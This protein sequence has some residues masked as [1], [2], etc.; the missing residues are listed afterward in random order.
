M[1]SPALG[2]PSAAA[3]FGWQSLIITTLIQVLVSGGALTPPVF[4]PEA[5]HDLGLPAA[6]IGFYTSLVYLGATLA[7]P[8]S[9]DL[10]GRHGPLR[11]SQICLLL[12]GIG[13]L[14]LTLTPFWPWLAVGSALLIGF[15]YGP[16]TPASSHILART[17]PAHR[18]GLVFSLKQ[19]GVPLGGM[20][21]GFAVPPL[22]YLWGWQ[23]A[24]AV[25][26]GVAIILA[27]AVQPARVTLDCQDGGGAARTG[28]WWR[29]IIGPV[30]LVW[31]HRRLRL[32]ACAS[33][34]FT[35]MQLSLGTFWVSYL[36]HDLSLTLLQAGVILAASQGG[37]VLGRILWGLMADRY[38]GARSM[39]LLLAVLMSACAL[40]PLALSPEWSLTALAL[41]SAGFGATA[42][43][44]NGVFLAEV[45]HMAPLGRTGEATGGVLFYTYAGVVFGPSLFG[46]LI[47][48]LGG[49]AQT[50]CVFSAL[51]FI[52]GLLIMVSGSLSEDKNAS[53]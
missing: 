11:T 36:V 10:I 13:L 4:A 43:G 51:T 39:L 33:F 37:G 25:V 49:Y 21:A 48:P 31:R 23:G 15:G 27:V 14:C 32:F 50:F 34:T 45:A 20:V 40:T 46:L 7:S 2:S 6:I 16:V 26:G 30:I 8:L 28:T 52:G 35:A 5:T 18:R 1:S 29:R 19:T 42:I 9:G 44:W 53:A 24:T 38:I 41:L 3:R 17:T 12:V 47:V 22:V